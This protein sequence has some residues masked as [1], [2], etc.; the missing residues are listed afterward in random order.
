MKAN[1]QFSMGGRLAVKQFLRR[2]RVV[3]RFSKLTILVLIILASLT[4][5]SCKED[6]GSADSEVVAK[7]GSREITL[8]QV[9]SAIKQQID[10][11][12]GG[13]SLTSVQL[14]AARLSALDK[15][16]Q[17]EALFQRAQKDNLVP[18]D[19]KV[20]QE[21]QKQK[22]D[23]GLTEEQY[24][25]Q[26]K[27]AGLTEDD[28]RDR[29]RR[30][31]AINALTE[32]ERTRVVAPTDA[33]IEKYFNDN[34]AQFVARAGV[35]MSMIV[36]DPADNGRALDDAKNETEAETKIKAI[37]EQLRGGSDFAT[38][39]AQRSEDQSYAQQGNI[40]FADEAA[41]RQTFPT[42]PELVS[43]FLAMKPGE[44]TEP[45]KDNLG[46]KWYI[47]KVNNRRDQTVN[48]TLTDVRKNI[49]DAI[50][51]QRQEI[52]LNAIVLVALENA[53][54]K[55]YLAERIARDP[56]TMI[57]LRPSELLQSATGSQPQ[58][59][60]RIENENSAPASPNANRSQAAANAN[61]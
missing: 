47:F 61:R 40:G 30:G 35:E 24:Q 59:Q 39:A 1:T 44:Y 36:A 45:V 9:D 37:F 14:V 21:V 10:A 34:K 49:V 7:V 27:R 52:L 26:L 50:T 17:E 4:A 48:L 25:E 46:N 16:I 18:D 58:P 12:G 54:V 33:E 38:I 42:R 23:A 20:T 11:A 41:L 5:L 13:V 8:R 19:G 43:R 29:I 2:S 15:L 31:I 51:R 60:P 57:E 6:A 56:K 3:F 32:K 55:N 53:N 22:Q 28:I